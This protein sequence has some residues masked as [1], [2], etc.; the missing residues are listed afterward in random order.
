MNLKDLLTMDLLIWLKEKR[1]LKQNEFFCNIMSFF[2]NHKILFVFMICYCYKINA[3]N[4]TLKPREIVYYP[5]A[6]KMETKNKDTVNRKAKNII[7][8]ELFGNSTSLGSINYERNII[9]KN[10]NWVLGFRGGFFYTTNKKYNESN[11]VLVMIN[12]VSNKNREYHFELGI[13]QTIRLTP[14]YVLYYNG[15]IHDTAKLKNLVGLTM[16]L[17][18]RYQ[19]AKGGLF[20]QVAY[21]PTFFYGHIFSEPGLSYLLYIFGAGVCFGYNF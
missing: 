17:G 1:D 5:V 11:S 7:F 14:T 10:N 3:Q 6:T 21:T 19:V 20:F 16:S 9:N 8:L 18:C 13:G 15:A 2:I 4:D 12:Y